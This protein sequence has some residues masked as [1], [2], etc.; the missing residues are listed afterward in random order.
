MIMFTHGRCDGARA[1]ARSATGRPAAATISVPHTLGLTLLRDGERASHGRVAG[2]WRQLPWPHAAQLRASERPRGSL[3]WQVPA[4]AR[5][6]AI[7]SALFEEA[8]HHVHLREARDEHHEKLHEREVLNAHVGRMERQEVALV[9]LLEELLLGAQLH[10]HLVHT[11]HARARVRQRRAA[12]RRE[13]RML[14]SRRPKDAHMTA[15]N[16]SAR[17][18]SVTRVHTLSSS[19]N[20]SKISPVTAWS[21]E[22]ISVDLS[23]VLTPRTGE[24]TPSMRPRTPASL[25]SPAPPAASSTL[26][27]APLLPRRLFLNVDL[28]VDCAQRRR[29]GPVHGPTSV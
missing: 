15:A 10:H 13:G 18:C 8:L 4:G 17:S 23:S 5:Y 6:R 19:A 25:P 22:A 26:P 3:L 29:S 2:R 28:A 16:A 27:L 11:L 20:S 12:P 7:W 24:S 21:F 14:R 1:V 9:A